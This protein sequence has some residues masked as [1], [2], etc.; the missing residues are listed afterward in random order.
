MQT[1]WQDLRYGARVLLKSPGFTI[2]AVFTLALGIGAN[3]AIF[4][5]MDKLMLRS[6]PVK[7]PERLVLLQSECLNPSMTFSQF[8]WADYNDYRAQNRVFN[9][10]TA[11]APQ[12]AN[13]GSGDQMER[14]RAEA[15][16]D[17]YFGM[18]GVQPML[19]R[20]FLPEENKTPGA[21]PV[22]VLSYS[23]WRSR[24]GGDSKVIGQTALLN[25][26]NYTIVGV[27]PANFTGMTVESPTDV[28]VPA[29]MI[30]QIA[31]RPPDDKWIS[32]RESWLFNL[33]GR[34]RPDVIR[35]SA[36]SAMDTLA[37]QVRDSWMPVTDRK[38]PF[39][40]RRMRLV[41]AGKGLSNLRGKMRQ[42]LQLIF[43]VVGLIL[44]IACANVANLSLARAGARR[45]EIAVRLALGAGRARLT[46]QLLTES[47]LLALLGGGAGTL[48]APWLTDLLLAYQKIT[49]TEVEVLSHSMNWRVIAFTFL[50]SSL[51]GLLFGLVPALQASK[52]DLIPALKD[53]GALRPDG[54][55]F[56]GSR[57]TL[58]VAQVALSVVVLAG[59]GL[60]LR[61]LIKLF[62]ISPGYNPDNVLVAKLELPK[63]KYDAARSEEFYR[64]LLERL[65]ALPDV[66]SVAMA[67]STPLSGSVRISTFT[68]EGQPIKP[69]EMSTTVYN[70]VSAGYHELVGIQL[71][72]GRGF[73]EQ[74]RKG[75]SHVAIV[76]EAFA[77]RYFP[78]GQALGKRVSLEMDK[79]PVE[80]V[81]VTRSIRS[82]GLLSED[83]PQIDLLAAQRGPENPMRALVRARRDAASLAPAVRREVRGF[84]PGLAFFKTTTLKDDLRA[85]ISTQRMAA[86][87]I[88]LFGLLA[89]ALTA[90]GLYGVISYSVERRVRE[91]GI[92]MALGAQSS[93]VLKLVMREGAALLAAGLMVGLAGAWA[94]TRLIKGQLYEVSPTDPLTFIGIAILLIFVA[95]M[96]C[97]IPAR[98]AT[99]VDPMVALK[100]E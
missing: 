2:V 39:N 47:L 3:T 77:R 83:R 76:N 45:K 30:G 66:Q 46:R 97:Y 93:D 54:A 38:L 21:N 84:D 33:A 62:A 1:L 19:G 56:K 90:I 55:S 35:E 10:L 74:D 71:L 72:Q 64:Q 52:P 28:W 98:R 8:S 87:L 88:G 48:F 5:L 61:S 65:K 49:E 32:D 96:A 29:M 86:A 99:K 36:E 94:A 63:T 82:L 13:L 57:R 6:L 75:S 9:D 37:L 25:D 26:T 80:I 15:V 68:I 51:T 100:Y 78:D 22:A 50:V 89:L 91:I 85:S 18:L 92:R 20:A 11:F 67:T 40:E 17:N 69:E 95:A 43:A 53:E 60:L 27:A 81:G 41:A 12:P 24:F 31:Q 79:P 4:G 70:T 58:I 14:V 59:A 73:T 42:L 16:A 44:L 23:L 34:L 7:D